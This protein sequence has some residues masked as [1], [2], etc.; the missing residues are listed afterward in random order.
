MNVLQYEIFI[1][2]GHIRFYNDQIKV[3]SE[4]ETEDSY[5]PAV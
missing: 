3:F 2:L 5:I 1:H 4:A